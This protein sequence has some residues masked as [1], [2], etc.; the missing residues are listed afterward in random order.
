MSSIGQIGCKYSDLISEYKVSVLYVSFVHYHTIPQICIQKNKH[1]RAYKGNIFATLKTK[2]VIFLSSIPL[3]F[4][5]KGIIIILI[6]RVI[7]HILFNRRVSLSFIRL[8]YNL[9]KTLSH[10]LGSLY[11]LNFVLVEYHL[12]FPSPSQGAAKEHLCKSL[13]NIILLMFWNICD[14]FII[15]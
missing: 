10:W 6:R 14:I 5:Q 11:H 9:T 15:E 2:K 1:W 12:L 13:W 4:L 3:R 7:L 8:H